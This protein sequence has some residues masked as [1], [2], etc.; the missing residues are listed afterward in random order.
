MKEFH[1]D[2]CKKVIGQ[3]EEDALVCSC[4][5]QYYGIEKQCAKCK[6]KELNEYYQDINQLLDD[7]EEP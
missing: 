6:H 7:E 4:M 3:V 2:T 5:D 1:C